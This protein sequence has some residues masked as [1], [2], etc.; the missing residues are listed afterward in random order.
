MDIINKFMKDVTSKV[1]K[2]FFNL[3]FYYFG[4]WVKIKKKLV[5]KNNKL[6][7]WDRIELPSLLLQNRALTTKQPRLFFDL[8][9]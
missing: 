2:F 7:P 9:N 4:V 1:K 3:F 6:L 8:N 5:E